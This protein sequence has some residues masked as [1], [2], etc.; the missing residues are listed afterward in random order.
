MNEKSDERMPHGKFLQA[1]SHPCW[2]KYGCMLPQNVL[3]EYWD[4]NGEVIKKIYCERYKHG[5]CE[6]PMSDKESGECFYE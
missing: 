6:M 4:H 3:I 5:L 2:R 1:V